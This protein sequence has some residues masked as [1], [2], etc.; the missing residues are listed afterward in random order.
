MAPYLGMNVLDI[1]C[2]SG[3]LI[4]FLSKEASYKGVDVDPES[5]NSLKL[6]YPEHTF[7]CLD[8]DKDSLTNAIVGV[9]LSSIVLSAVIEHLENPDTVLKQCQSLMNDATR[10]VVTTPTPIGDLVSRAIERMIFRNRHRK[11]IH[12]HL[13]NYSKKALV[14]LGE[15][16]G[17]A[18][19]LYRRLGWHRQNQLAIYHRAAIGGDKNSES[20]K[21]AVK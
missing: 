6:R 1:G 19:I 21:P 14:S 3:V 20:F 17:L 4:P 18:C 9:S 2:G 8:L 7:H 12:P 16:H 5:V 10:L 11:N 15:G 13:R